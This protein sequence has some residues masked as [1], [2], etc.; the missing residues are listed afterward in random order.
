MI[1]LLSACM[2]IYLI[3]AKN[4]E[5]STLDFADLFNSQIV[6]NMDNFFNEYDQLTKSVLVDSEAISDLRTQKTLTISEQVNQQ[7]ELRR[8]MMRL[9][10]VKPEIISVC[11]LTEDG[12]LFNSGR[13]G[14][15]LSAVT[16]SEQSWVERF[17]R[18]DKQTLGITA[19]HNRE[20]SDRS[21]DRI[22]L[23]VIRKILDKGGASVGLL[24]LDLEPAA[25]VKLSDR[26]LLARN[27]YNIKI[28]VTNDDHEL[29][30]DSDVASGQITWEHAAKSDNN[31]F[32]TKNPKDYVQIT[33]RSEHGGLNVNA[34]IPRSDLLFKINRVGYATALSMFVCMFVVVTIS[35]FIS[36]FITKLVRSL[37][38]NMKNV[39]KGEYRLIHEPVQAEGAN[40]IASL[41]SSYN[42]MVNKIKTL[43]EE[44][45][46]AE[47]EQKDA[48]LAALQLQINPHMLYNTLESIRMK[49]I[50]SD[51]DEIADMVKILAKMFRLALNS[52]TGQHKVRDEVEYARNY[53]RLQNIRYKDAFSLTVDLD[54]R[55]LES[56]IIILFFQPLIEN[57]IKHA[58][59]KNSMALHVKIYGSLT[60]SGDMLL[61]LEDDGT[62]MKEDRMRTI[63]DML[64]VA[65]SRNASESES[66]GRAGRYSADDDFGV[67]AA[68]AGREVNGTA[69]GDSQE[70]IGLRN[71]ARRIRLFCGNKYYLRIQKS[72]ASGTVIEIKLPYSGEGGT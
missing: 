17:R 34:V 67:D 58:S 40:E 68:D 61:Y 31:I 55:I 46:V 5:E 62:G 69:S 26:F 3:S 57:S 30:Y 51:E 60:E 48:Q 44:V 21:Q 45:L 42:H 35:S 18:L 7:L 71:I 22:V 36:R 53:L 13:T 29:I 37:E 24:I 27:Q 43:V 2:A 72:D 20:Y 10:T 41:I 65:G 47:I 49:A 15:N 70:S 19:I 66:Y 1:P 9:I 39:E 38:Q 25:L 11:I 14:E 33:S 4:L 63:N 8:I 32:Y 16:L 6:A 56:D 54:S 50:V 59:D 64:S 52:K 12:Q 28:S 23:S